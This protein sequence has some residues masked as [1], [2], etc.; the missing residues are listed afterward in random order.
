MTVLR[1]ASG[2][3]ID[4]DECPHHVAAPALSLDQLRSATGYVSHDD[5]DYCPSCW[6]QHTASGSGTSFQPSHDDGP[7]AA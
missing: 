1:S 6:Y 7:T 4:C 2:A 5:R 3:R